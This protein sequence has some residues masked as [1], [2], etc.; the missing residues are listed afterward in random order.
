MK[1]TTSSKPTKEPTMTTTADNHRPYKI[2]LVETRVYTIDL[3]SEQDGIDLTE[4]AAELWRTGNDDIEVMK[5]RKSELVHVD[6]QEVP[7]GR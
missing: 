3:K 2:T 5:L 7:W 1:S 6:V 4:W